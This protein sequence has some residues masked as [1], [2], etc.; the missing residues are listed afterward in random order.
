VPEKQM[1]KSWTVAETIISLVGLGMALLL[2]PMV[3]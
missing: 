3:K 2:W 1:L